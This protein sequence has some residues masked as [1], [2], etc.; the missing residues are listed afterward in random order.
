MTFWAT[1][2]KYFLKAYD[3]LITHQHSLNTQIQIHKYNFGQSC[4][5]AQHVLY[6]WSDGTRTS[7]N[8]PEYLMCKHINTNTQIQFWS[9][10]QMF[11]GVWH[12]NTQIQIH[13]N[14]NTALVKVADRPNISYIFEK[15][16][17]RGPQKQCSQVSDVQIHK[18]KYTYTNTQIQLRSK[19]QIDLTCAIF[20]K[21]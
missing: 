21:G 18:Y 17:V 19:L 13:K 8:V 16:M 4:T 5:K 20:L 3:Y 14:T 6:F 12:A 9:K 7:N 1:Q 15:V 10:L 11:P 2:T